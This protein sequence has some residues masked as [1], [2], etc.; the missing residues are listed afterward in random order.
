MVQDEDIQS[1][2]NN[3]TWTTQRAKSP[4]VYVF[5]VLP[6]SWTYMLIMRAPLRRSTQNRANQSSKLEPLEPLGPNNLK[7]PRSSTHLTHS[8][9][10]PPPIVEDEVASVAKEFD[11]YV[12]SLSDEEPKYRGT[13]EQLPV[14]IPVPEHNPERRFV[15]V[16]P[17]DTDDEPL[18]DIS[19]AQTAKPSAKARY[20]ANTKIHLAPKV[21]GHGLP[22]LQRR[23]SRPDLPRIETDFQQSAPPRPTSQLHRSRSATCVDQIQQETSKDYFSTHPESAQPARNSFLSPNFVKHATKGRDKAYWDLN[24]GPNGTDPRD[25]SPNRKATSADRRAFDVHAKSSHG[26]SPIAQRRLHSD[27]DVRQTRKPAERRGTYKGEAYSRSR[28]GPPSP[29]SD[30]RHSP[31]RLSRRETSPVRRQEESHKLSHTRSRQHSRPPPPK[32]AGLND[33]S[34]EYCEHRSRQSHRP[35]RKSIVIQEDHPSLL[36]PLGPR[37]PVSKSKSRPPSPL[38]SPK[39]SQMRFPDYNKPPCDPRK[40]TTSH[41]ARGKRLSEIERPVSPMSSGGSSPR[42]RS[43]LRTDDRKRAADLGR[44][45]ASSRTPSL[46]SNASSIKLVNGLTPLSTASVPLAATMPPTPT[47]SRQGSSETTPHPQSHWQPDPFQPPHQSFPPTPRQSGSNL[48]QSGAPVT[49]YRRYSEDVS[50][51]SLPGLP[52]C[53][54]QRPRAGHVDW[55]TLPRCDNL[56][57]CPSCYEQVLY[58]TEFRDQLVPAPMRSRDKEITCDLGTSPWYRIAWLMTLKYRRADLRLL[59]GIAD[60]S[61]RHRKAP[62][63]DGGTARV[64]RPWLSILDPQTRRCV[65]DFTVCDFCADAVQAL[66]PSLTGVFI[67][68]TSSLEPR[69]GRCS[70]RF[71]PGRAR[72]AVYFDAFESAHDRAVADRAPPSVRRLAEDIGFYSG[73]EECSRDEPGRRRQWYVMAHVPEVTVCQECFLD[74]VCPE[75]VADADAV[76]SAGGDGNGDGRA[77]RSVARDFY[78]EPQ[79]IK[80]AT[81]CQMARPWMRDLFK[82]ACRRDDGIEYLDSRVREKLGSL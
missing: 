66:F 80:S 81:V 63:H 6:T 16:A 73:I 30:R 14:L 59:Q 25:P 53:P 5:A 41:V 33:S 2:L 67:P 7:V 54:R 52:D 78:Q 32:E 55:L 12:A 60:A 57:I 27:M 1:L 10:A 34:D 22:D 75:L 68:T 44:P 11:G 62:C 39:A 42:S 82:R 76:A 47:W 36:S 29:S 71:A 69:Q 37:P 13:V 50:T 9:L 8:P 28:N 51:G 65:P 17:L 3:G 24:P 64:T 56:H 35:R 70:L 58:P 26:T 46:K 40:S 45:V 61:S 31:P 74:V 72:F 18:A 4:R 23:K 49:S 79:V 15:L 20:E 21:P 38:P 43:K 19:E 77:V 48:E